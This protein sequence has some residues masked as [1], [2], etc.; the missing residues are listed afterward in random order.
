MKKE[1]R[2]IFTLMLEENKFLT[3]LWI[4][5][6][7]ILG[8]LPS[9]TILV[10]KEL[11]NH[12]TSIQSLRDSNYKISVFFLI[13]ISVL[14]ISKELIKSISEYIYTKVKFKVSYRLENKLYDKILNY[15]MEKFEDDNMYNSILMA[16]QALQMN[17]LDIINLFINSISNVITIISVMFTLLTINVFL[18]FGLTI[19]A[20]PGLIGIL[21]IKKYKFKVKESLLELVR[22]NNYFTYLFTEK[23]AIREIKIF[24]LKNY[25]ENIWRKQKEEIIKKAINVSFKENIVSLFGQIIVNISIALASIFFV[26]M[27]VE[28][29]L[30]LGGFVSLLTAVTLFQSTIS[31]MGENNS[32]I[33]EMGLYVDALFKV[34]EK[35]EVYESIKNNMV[36][37]EPIESIEFRN[38]NFQYRQ[39]KK[40]T[41]KNI[42][43][44]INK[45]DRIAIVGYNGSG[46]TTLV[47]L[48]LGLYNQNSGDIYINGKDKSHYD[49]DE[50]FKKITCIMQDYMKY[51]FSLLENVSLGNVDCLKK[52]ERVIEIL[53]KM[54]IGSDKLERLDDI[55]SAKYSGGFELSGGE[56]Q[57]VAISRAMI[58]DAEIVIFDE[59]TSSLDPIAEVNIYYDLNELTDNKTSIIISHR[60]GVTKFCNKIIVMKEGKIVEIGNHDELMNLEGEYAY[61]YKTQVSWYQT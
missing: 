49:M 15:S 18:P 5:L 19:A 12:I 26:R 17:S 6:S 14:A 41:L 52:R 11:V 22:K 48:I 2:V 38:V 7:L 4:L 50:Y 34:L 47:N 24:N 29:K 32:N 25:F 45:G 1:Y 27:I 3:I 59:P 36:L 61:L 44:M 37:R 58:R 23:R 46:K 35:N 10:N 40:M 20:L 31:V 39:S 55:L 8:V 57:K 21:C 42:S 13:L 43:L 16:S 56:W 28:G 60:L 30:D 53:Q 9:F 51:D 33:Y 54:K